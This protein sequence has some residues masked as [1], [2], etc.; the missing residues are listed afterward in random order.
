MFARNIVKISLA[1][2]LLFS[3][4]GC[5]GGGNSNTYGSLSLAVVAPAASGVV[6]AKATAALVPA[7]AG[8]QVSFTAKMYGTDPATPGVVTQQPAQAANIATDKNG[9]AEWPVN[10]PN[11][12]YDT[13]LEVTANSAGL[14]KTVQ[15]AIPAYVPPAP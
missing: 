4:S 2:A 8:T 7:L 15:V 3:L 10:F 14:F 6:N 13:T 11:L 12:T 1:A 5:G 9:T